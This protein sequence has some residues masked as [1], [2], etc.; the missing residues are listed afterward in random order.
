MVLFPMMVKY[1][2]EDH[3]GGLAELVRSTSLSIKAHA[4]YKLLIRNNPQKAP[5]VYKQNFPAKCWHCPMPESFFSEHCPDNA[6]D[7][8]QN[9]YYFDMVDQHN[10]LKALITASKLD[11]VQELDDKIKEFCEIVKTEIAKDGGI[12]AL[13]KKFKN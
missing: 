13:I 7:K 4:I 9:E 12:E 8:S 2:H 10:G 5:P 11:P 6:K 1:G 3:D